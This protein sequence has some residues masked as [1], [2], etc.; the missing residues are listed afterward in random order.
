AKL[1]TTI[2]GEQRV[3]K[4]ISGLLEGAS[5]PEF[6]DS[7]LELWN[8][9][10]GAR[11]AKTKKYP[12]TGSEHVVTVKELLLFIKYLRGKIKSEISEAGFEENLPV[13]ND[14]LSSE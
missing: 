4:E 2:D 6:Y 14:N 11:L 1:A 5:K 7:S 13:L 12:V 9:S 8:R 10:A 3:R